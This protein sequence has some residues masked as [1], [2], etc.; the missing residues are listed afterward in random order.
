MVLTFMKQTSASWN[1]GDNIAENKDGRLLR[2]CARKVWL[3]FADDVSKVISASIIRAV[4]NET[5][6]RWRQKVPTKRL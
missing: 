2:C 5:P 3:K 4:S 6:W 1:E